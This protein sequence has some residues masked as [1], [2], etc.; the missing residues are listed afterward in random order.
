MICSRCGT[1]LEDNLKVC[2]NCG[3]SV[4]SETASQTAQNKGVSQ[5]TARILA[6]IGAMAMIAA[7]IGSALHWAVGPLGGDSPRTVVGGLSTD[8]VITLILSILAIGLF[9]VAISGKAKWAFLVGSALSMSV[10][11]ITIYDAI[12]M[13]RILS[14]EVNYPLTAVGIGLKICIVG[15]AIG[16]VCGICGFLVPKKSEQMPT[17]C[18][19]RDRPSIIIPSD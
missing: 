4:G 14:G 10:L 6:A 1:Q 17:S 5:T 13:G 18:P 15:A 9:F 16:F 2:T 11:L 3:A 8:G 12:Y 7:A 19:A